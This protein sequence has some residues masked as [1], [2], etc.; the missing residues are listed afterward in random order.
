MNRRA[1][2]QARVQQC[3]GI[4]ESFVASGG[5][6]PAH[7]SG[8]RVALVGHQRHLWAPMQFVLDTTD[9]EAVVIRDGR[10]VPSLR[11]RIESNYR[12]A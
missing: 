2:F 10:I 12:A 9:F 3:R 4:L 1:L 7:G 5:W 8:W 11:A 6:L